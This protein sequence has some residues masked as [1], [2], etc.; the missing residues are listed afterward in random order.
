MSNFRNDEEMRQYNDSYNR[1]IRRIQ[2]ENERKDAARK[3][4]EKDSYPDKPS[5]KEF[6]IINGGPTVSDAEMSRLA[7]EK[8]DRLLDEER[9]LAALR[10]D[11]ENPAKQSVDEA[12]ERERKAV[13]ER[14][15]VAKERRDQ[16]VRKR[17]RDR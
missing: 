15:K 14:M 9:K 11:Q 17:G 12:R 16:Q 10:R 1:E 2:E 3:K 4:W 6:E 7:R 13:E 5:A 8:A